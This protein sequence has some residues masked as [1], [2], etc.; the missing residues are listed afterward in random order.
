M[1]LELMKRKVELLK[2]RLEYLESVSA[3]SLREEDSKQECRF[4]M[5]AANQVVAQS[6]ET[7]ETLE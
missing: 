2:A 4:D 5:S 1:E 7:R 6:G 3:N